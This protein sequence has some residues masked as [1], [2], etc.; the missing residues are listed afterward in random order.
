M[1]R[2]YF[3]WPVKFSCRLRVG[4]PGFL[5]SLNF[6]QRYGPAIIRL[7]TIISD[8]TNNYKINSKK[9]ASELRSFSYLFQR[10][11]SD[12]ENAT[13]EDVLKVLGNKKSYLLDAYPHLFKVYSI[14]CAIPVSSCTAERSFSTVKRVKTALRSTMLESRLE[15]LMLINVEN[16]ILTKIDKKGIVDSYAASSKTLSRALLY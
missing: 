6:D 3:K 12:A 16:T 8:L 14:I 2:W 10:L 11:N 9:C 4:P 15:N 1:K 7:E 13:F 5:P